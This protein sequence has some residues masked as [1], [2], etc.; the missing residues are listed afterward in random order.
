MFI[1]DFK[2]GRPVAYRLVGNLKIANLLTT[3]DA[4]LLKFTLEAPQ[5][6]VRPHGS[7]SQTEFHVHK[8]P[9]DSYGNHDFYAIWKLGNVSDIYFEANENV[10]LTNVKK[11]IVSLF[12][13]QTNDGDYIETGASGSCDVQYRQTSQTGIRQKRQNCVL[14]SKINHFVRPEE[15]LQMTAQNY[16]STDYRFYPDGTIDKIESRDYFHIALEAN[17]EIGSSVDSIVVIQSDDN[18]AKV[19]TTGSKSP[20]EFLS[21]L[22]NYKGES[23]ETNPQIIKVPV[24]SNIKKA[25][26]HFENELSTTNIGTVQSAKAFLNILPIA[27]VAR[28]EDIVQLL[29]SKKLAEIKVRVIEINSFEI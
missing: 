24:D 3:E 20:K 11:A 12:Q 5:L 13:F 4:K 29:K 8:S 14:K 27:R 16:R 15:P 9:L 1:K 7:D 19:Q 25:I 6:H 23:L 21:Q 17:R 10:A 22:N 26:K 28:K 2:N 18:I